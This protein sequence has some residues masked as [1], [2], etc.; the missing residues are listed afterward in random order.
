MQ[1]KEPIANKGV[2]G[3]DALAAKNIL[4]RRA[5][6]WSFF[7]ITQFGIR[8]PEVRA[9]RCT[10]TAGRASK[11]GPRALLI[12]RGAQERAPTGERNCVHPG[13]DAITSRKRALE[14][15]EFRLKLPTRTLSRHPEVRALA[16]LEG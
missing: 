2:T 6:Q 7:I 11:D 14:H 12:L 15:D 9:L 16:R 5:N 1:R 3:M 8:H 10:C 4:T 13:D